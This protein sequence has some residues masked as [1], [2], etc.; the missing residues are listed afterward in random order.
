MAYMGVFAG[1]RNAN[2]M[3]SLRIYF[4]HFQ[5]MISRFFGSALC[6]CCAKYELRLSSNP[7]KSR[8]F[9]IR[10]A[11]HE[12]VRFRSPSLGCHFALPHNGSA[13]EGDR[14]TDRQ[15]GR[16]GLSVDLRR[17]EIV[18]HQMAQHLCNSR[19]DSDSECLIRSDLEVFPGFSQHDD[20]FLQLNILRKIPFVPGSEAK[21]TV[22]L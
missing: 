1:L 2:G 22:V 15:T 16:H 9:F 10:G 17:R 20:F 5:I 14:P 19:Q 6:L 18:R 12:V 4:K 13:M 21:D 7:L 3:C 11:V 8:D